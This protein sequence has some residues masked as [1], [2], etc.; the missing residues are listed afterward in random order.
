MRVAK[1]KIPISIPILIQLFANLLW[2]NSPPEWTI[3]HKYN[4]KTLF[5]SIAVPGLEKKIYRTFL[6]VDINKR[7][8][9]DDMWGMANDCMEEI[10]KEIQNCRKIT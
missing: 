5:I 2:A 1:R 6:S 4:G 9:E 10:K 7:S 3:E 8:K